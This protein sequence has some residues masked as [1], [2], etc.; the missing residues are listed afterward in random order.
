MFRYAVAIAGCIAAGCGGGGVVPGAGAATVTFHLIAPATAAVTPTV[1]V[2][3]GA[4]V[5]M[6]APTPAVPHYT[7]TAE[8]GEGATYR[9]SVG[10][11][12]EAF[13]RRVPAGRAE[14]YNDVFQR[15]VTVRKLPQFPWPLESEGFAGAQW[16]RAA[17]RAPL[18]NDSYVPTVYFSGARGIESQV[19][20]GAVVTCTLYVV[21]QD[22]ILAFPETRWHPY[23]SDTW[24][25][26]SLIE[27]T[28]NT[29]AVGG[30]A[31]FKARTG[32]FDPTQ[33]R[34]KT[35]T[36]MMNALGAPVAQQIH[37]RFYSNGKPLGLFILT[38]LVTNLAGNVQNAD[39]LN[40][41]VF[42][43]FE[44]GDSALL[45]KTGIPLI[46]GTGATMEYT[47]DNPEVYN[48]CYSSQMYTSGPRFVELVK[49]LSLVGASSTERQLQ[50]F[51]DIF[52]VDRFLRQ[53]VLEVSREG[54]ARTQGAYWDENQ[55]KK[56]YFTDNDF[57]QTFG[58]ANAYEDGPD[59]SYKTYPGR[60]AAAGRPVGPRPLI[61]N[62]LKAPAYRARFEK[63]LVETVRR[64]FNPVA[65]GR[66][67]DA[68]VEVLR[69]EVAWDHSFKAD[70]NRLF[71]AAD[72][73]AGLTGA[74]VYRGQ[75]NSGVGNGLYTWVAA[76]AR[77]VA[78]EFNFQ[79]DPVA[80]DP[81]ELRPDFAL[82][83]E[84]NKTDTAP[85][86]AAPGAASAGRP[87]AAPGFSVPRAA[88]GL[89]LY[90]AVLYAGLTL[91]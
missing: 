26:G 47:G 20:G 85:G 88:L 33:L 80:Q 74:V 11:V 89:A 24:K 44:G 64:M 30:R 90:S 45:Q 83:V 37:A 48:A 13:E 52:D 6:T 7:A 68:F 40:N 66:R 35:Y 59:K 32:E 21:L 19:E 28:Q 57:D 14:T 10:G 54:R 25:W 27:L 36:D 46:C 60:T 22:R 78:A 12:S 58:S 69:P 43:V 31:W 39:C 91:V 3:G 49:K 87:A 84:P 70:G 42:H 2:S 53:M 56:W 5:A 38:D 17:P 18:F 81:P 1:T 61:E 77:A 23:K 62:L 82:A 4:A 55:T 8:V 79:W 51:E 16:Q 86:P 67:M 63:I 29:E 9:Y 65:F 15:S 72:F 41:H 75:N 76:R 71:S 50:D 73:D 34:E